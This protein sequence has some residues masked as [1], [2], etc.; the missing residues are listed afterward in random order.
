M[1][2]SLKYDFHLFIYFGASALMKHVN[3]EDLY[4][5][6]EY[7]WQLENISGGQTESLTVNYFFNNPLP[8]CINFYNI[9][10]RK[11]TKHFLPYPKYKF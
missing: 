4:N 7:K 9:M 3:F 10:L 2:L 6:K 11:M 1:C 5:L 8:F